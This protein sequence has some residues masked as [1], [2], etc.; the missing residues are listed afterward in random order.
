MSG[1]RHNA[2]TIY[3]RP[4]DNTQEYQIVN[5]AKW[6]VRLGHFKTVK[7]AHGYIHQ[8]EYEKPWRFKTLMSNYYAT[9]FR[10]HVFKKPSKI[11]DYTTGSP[12]TYGDEPHMYM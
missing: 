5:A 1:Y 10:G 9:H 4:V 6:L 3:L 12:N 7:I 8:L 11:D 2:D